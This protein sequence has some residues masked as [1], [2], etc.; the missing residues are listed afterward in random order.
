MF[1]RLVI[2]FVVVVVVVHAQFQQL[3]GMMKFIN[4]AGVNL[5]DI[6]SLEM[7]YEGMVCCPADVIINI[8]PQQYETETGKY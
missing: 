6:M 2:C 7:K 8:K 1:G 4:K 5:V 3:M